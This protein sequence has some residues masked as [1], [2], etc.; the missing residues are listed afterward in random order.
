MEKINVYIIAT[1][2]SAVIALVVYIWTRTVS[3]YDEQIETLRNDVKALKYLYTEL[4][5]E[6][7]IRT[8]KKK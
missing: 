7:N 6:H 4:H 2:G 1:L 3:E 8:C 5:T